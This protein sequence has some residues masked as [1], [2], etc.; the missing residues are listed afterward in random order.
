ME[1]KIL[2]ACSSRH[3]A[4]AEI[5][6][7]IG[8]VLR[9]KGRLAEVRPVGTVH[10]L[11]PYAAVLLGSALYFGG[12]PQDAVRF[13]QSHAHRLA[14]LPVWLF[15]SGPTGAGDP[16]AR[17]EG[18]LYPAAL[19]PLIGQIRPRGITAFGGKLDPQRLNPLERWIIGRVK[20]PWGDYRDWEAVAAW[21]E[22]IG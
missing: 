4:T 22:G 18:Q 10:D 12:W 6:A 13:V 7:R 17:L 3:G 15:V 5:A 16:L 11:S 2:V 20:A 19:R 21:A 1:K 8:A 14:E 9:E